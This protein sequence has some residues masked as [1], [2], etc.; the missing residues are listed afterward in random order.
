MVMNVIMMVAFQSTLGY[1]LSFFLLSSPIFPYLP[2]FSFTRVLCF[3]SFTLLFSFSVLRI[4]VC[5]VC[6]VLMCVHLCDNLRGTRR[7]NCVCLRNREGN[8]CEYEI[9][10]EKETESESCEGVVGVFE[11]K[12][13]IKGRAKKDFGG[14]G[15]LVVIMN[16]FWYQKKK[17]VPGGWSAVSG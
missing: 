13:M 11:T 12:K 2:L 8:V 16:F 5:Y 14:V 6:V 9:E 17:R 4:S 7:G 10:G 3:F 15:M 1:L